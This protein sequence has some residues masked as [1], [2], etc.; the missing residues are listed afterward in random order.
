VEHDVVTV[1]GLG[2]SGL[3]NGELPQRRQTPDLK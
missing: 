1:H 3:K 2:W